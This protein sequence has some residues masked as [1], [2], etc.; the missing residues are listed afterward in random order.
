M[1]DVRP[2]PEPMAPA[3]PASVDAIDAGWLGPILADSGLIAPGAAIDLV[4]ERIGADRGFTG[5]V[6]RVAWRAAGSRSGTVVVKLPDAA[7]AFERCAREVLFYEHFAPICGARVPRFLFGAADPA[8][9]AV[10]L[11]IEDVAGTPGDVMTGC[12]VAEAAALVVELARMHAR[13]WA[14]PFVGGPRRPEWLPRWGAGTADAATP[15][16]RAA[17]R[18]RRHLDPFFDRFGAGA[19]PRLRALAEAIAPRCEDLMAR[20]ACGPLTL[21]HADVHL[22]N[23]IFRAPRR[24]PSSPRPVLLD[25]QSVSAGPAMYDL[26]RALAD[27]LHGATAHGG[28]IHDLVE[29]YAARL[30]IE[31]GGRASIGDGPAARR[32]SF[33]EMMRRVLVGMV[34]GYGGRDPAAMLPRERDLVA[35]SLSADGLAGVVLAAER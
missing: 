30:A 17:D 24:D 11:V 3:I 5:D 33:G 34:S 32:R 26:A 19:D 1:A 23:V 6:A 29:L 4:V 21:I 18:F 15:H 22:D 7:G 13:W 14:H 9:A 10:V 28:A 8:A 12:A 25:W 20:V 27:T 16:R 2:A 31:S 35:R